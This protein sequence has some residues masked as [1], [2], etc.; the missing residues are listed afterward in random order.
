VKKPELLAPGGSFLSALYAFEAGADGVYLGLKEFSARRAAQNFTLDQ[1]RRIRQLAADKGRRIYVTVN[2]VIRDEELGRLEETFAWLQ[3]MAVDGVIVQDLGV[4]DLLA[5]RF[6]RLPI[7]ASTQMALHNDAGLAMAKELGIRRVILSRELP[8]GRITE[9]R[10]RNPG[11]ELEVF[12]HGALCF[13]FSGL[14]LASWELTGRSGNRGDC[15]QICRSLFREE[16]GGGEGIEGH[17]FSCR[18]LFLGR[19]VLALADAGVDALKIEGRMKSPEYVFNVT[20]LYREI[21]DQGEELPEQKYKELARRAELGFAREKT[22][23]WLRSAHGSGLIAKDFPG[24]RGALLG[25]AASVRGRD[26]TV[27]IAGDL[28]L[29]D[30][31]AYFVKDQPEP[32][33]FSVG[34]IRR[35]GRE[36]PFARAGETVTIEVPPEAGRVMP[37]QGQEI[38]HLSSRFLDLP[39]PRESGFRLFKVPIDLEISLAG[40]GTLSIQAVAQLRGI[41]RKG[42]VPVQGCPPF[43][44]AVTVDRAARPRSFLQLFS[45]LLGESGDSFFQPG[46]VAFLNSTGFA[47]DGIFV[48]PSELKRAKNDFYAFLGRELSFIRQIAAADHAPPGE[49][50]AASPLAPEDLEMLAHRE[51]LTPTG[52]SPVPFVGNDPGS[53]TV[54]QL[55]E[56]AGFRWIP[57]PPVIMG[58]A[59]WSGSLRRLLQDNPGVRFAIGMNNLSHVALVRSFEGIPNAWFFA[60]FFLYAA[61]S[62]AVGLMNRLVQPLLFAY[63]WLEAGDAGAS[64]PR[65]AS[66][67]DAGPV[68]IVRMAR[69]FRP[70]LFYSF[71]CFARHILNNGRCYDTCPKDFKNVLRQGK[72]R[73]EVVVRD[74]VTYLFLADARSG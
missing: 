5:R 6:P 48:P 12:I 18:D 65:D 58:D 42:G 50:P 45:T 32:V 1:L 61:N 51:L 38:R 16:A 47:D 62:R 8:L 52:M 39:Q 35:A 59:Q 3:A 55:P 27:Q 43:Q 46:E 63:E 20:R 57:L 29:R 15:A 37:A 33:A 21:L 4:C 54:S 9:L 14:C 13:S 53:L 26:F 70:P 34:L 10:E 23:G 44:A 49:R 28:S 72:N 22:S 69:D 74:C 68:P 30:G 36:V 64:A 71:G 56:L 66:L 2:T 7:H 67:S 31:L 19:E 11:I 17:L 24:H 40:D 60:D 73:F 41:P 25:S